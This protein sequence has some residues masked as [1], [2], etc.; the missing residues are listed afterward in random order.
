MIKAEETQGFVGRPKRPRALILGPTKELTEQIAGVA[1]AL[2]HTAKFRTV[3]L[4]GSKTRK[5]QQVQLSG[6]V[7]VL[8]ATPTRFLQ[9]VRDG[10]VFYKDINWL[11]V[12]E[13][14]TML[15]DPTWAAELKTILV[16]LRERPDRPKVGGSWCLWGNG[17]VDRRWVIVP[18]KGTAGSIKYARSFSHIW[19]FACMQ[20]GV[21]LVSATMNKLIR[22]LIASDFP[23]ARM[24]E[25]SSLHKGIAG[26]RHVFMRQPPGRDKLDLLGDMLAPDARQQ[27]KVWGMNESV[28]GSAGESEWL[29]MCGSRQG[30]HMRTRTHTFITRCSYDGCHKQLTT[31]DL[32]YG[33][34]STMHDTPHHCSMN[35]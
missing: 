20:A 34:W 24:L 5:Q 29:R 16:P 1:R 21:V 7:D 12:D 19:L 31:T 11:V 10:N 35:I 25:T 18:L 4:T 15:A 17:R 6:P 26:S 22:R 9:H 2:S 8:V 23:G 32:I 27:T 28:A 13:A 14:D 33:R 30:V 3:G